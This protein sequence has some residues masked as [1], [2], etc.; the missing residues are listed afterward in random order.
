[1]L[2]S[3]LT[4]LKVIIMLFLNNVILVLFYNSVILVLFFYNSVILVLDTRISAN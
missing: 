1:M 4:F 2:L 3:S